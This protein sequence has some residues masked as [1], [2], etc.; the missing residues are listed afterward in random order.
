MSSWKFGK[1]ASPSSEGSEFA[2]SG[3]GW[4]AGR[5]LGLSAVSAQVYAQGAAAELGS[6]VELARAGFEPLRRSPSWPRRC[7]PASPSA[8]LHFGPDPAS[9]G[10]DPQT[11]SGS[12]LAAE[13]KEVAS[14]RSAA[15]TPTASSPVS[16][17][18]TPSTIPDV[19]AHH[20][21]TAAAATESSS[22]AAGGA[23]PVPRS[24]VLTIRVVEARN[25]N[26]PEGVPLPSGIRDAVEQAQAGM[27]RGARE[28]L[29]RKQMWWL[30]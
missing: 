9:A 8:A 5:A 30:P 13:L 15:S 23:A 25:L 6:T 12:A 4:A 3:G 20:A 21:A 7:L 24:G 27:A 19:A 22:S 26:P 28:S 16:A 17:A 29:Q 10:D 2:D 11:D 14:G 1:S 18:S